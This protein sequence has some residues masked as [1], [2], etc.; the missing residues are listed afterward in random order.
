MMGLFGFMYVRYPT[1]IDHEHFCCLE[2]CLGKMTREY[3]RVPFRFAKPSSS[4]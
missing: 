3:G 4:S 1:H 2:R